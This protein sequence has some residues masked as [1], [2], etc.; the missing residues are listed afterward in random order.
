MIK[1]EIELSDNR[2]INLSQ[3]NNGRIIQSS[4]QS[5]KI[6]TIPKQI[7][8]FQKESSDIMK[9]SNNKVNNQES[10]EDQIKR[11]ES[12]TQEKSNLHLPSNIPNKRNIVSELST[13]DS[14]KNIKPSYW[15]KNVIKNNQEN[16]CLSL[17]KYIKYL[18]SI[19]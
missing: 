4:I 15:K 14:S 19:S 5:K 8:A 11:L 9:I 6:H 7:Q 17:A 16:C 1:E 2:S 13:M 18:L 10:Q 12:I 3:Q